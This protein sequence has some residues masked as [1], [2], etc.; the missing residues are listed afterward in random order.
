MIDT[1]EERGVQ[2]DFDGDS[3]R[4]SHKGE[5]FALGKI[6]DTLGKDTED[7]IRAS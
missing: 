2:A 1:T 4:V 7:A 5:R 3:Y 6:P